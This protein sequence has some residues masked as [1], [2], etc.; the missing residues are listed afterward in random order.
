MVSAVRGRGL[1]LA[2]EL[3]GV[4]SAD[5][6][7][8]LRVQGILANP[9]AADAIRLAPAL[10]ITDLDLAETVTRWG[11]AFASLSSPT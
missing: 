6:D 5:V 8:A 11:A 7:I 9:V 4:T 3:N 1:L 10:N 2:T